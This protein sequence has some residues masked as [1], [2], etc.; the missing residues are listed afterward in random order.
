[1]DIII[2]ES[3]ACST[4][5]GVLRYVFNKKAS[6]RTA[7]DVIIIKVILSEAIKDFWEH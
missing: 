7:I 2:I 4:K 1:M 6:V 5:Y 3:L